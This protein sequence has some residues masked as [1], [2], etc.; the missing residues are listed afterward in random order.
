MAALLTIEGL[1]ASVGSTEIL[2]GVDLQVGAGEVHGVM[3]PN[4]SGK[5][6]LAHVLAGRPGPRVTGGR[7]TLSGQDL[8]ALAPHERARLGLFVGLQQPIEVPGVLPGVALAMAGAPEGVV[9]RLARGAEAVGLRA[10]LL[11]RPLNV[12]LSGGERKRNEVAQLLA[13][14]RPLAVLDEVDSGLDVDALAEVAGALRDAVAEWGL[15]VVAITHFARILEVLR[16]T[17]VHVLLHG[18][19]VVRGGPELAARIEAQG[20]VALSE[21]T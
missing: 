16:P 4:G 1:S 8:L 13:L 15:A 9:T 5:S 2:R 20:Y 17:A 19:I 14:R 18:R 21:G 10:E 6:T 12:D 11:D 7:V 3:G